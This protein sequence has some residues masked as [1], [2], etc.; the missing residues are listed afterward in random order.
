M[1]RSWHKWSANLCRGIYMTAEIEI[2]L[3]IIWFMLKHNSDFWR[4]INMNIIVA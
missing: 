4:N 1:S 3:N 2:M